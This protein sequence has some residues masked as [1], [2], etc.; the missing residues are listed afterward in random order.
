MRYYLILVIMAKMNISGNNRCWWGC[1]ERTL[2]RCWWECRVVRPL[3]KMVWRF[4]KKLKTELPCDL[5]IALL[6]I[7]PKGTKMLIQRGTCTPLF[8]AVLSTIAKLW[9]EP[10]CPSTDEWIKM[11]CVHVHA[12]THTHT[13]TQ[14]GILLHD[15]KEWNLAIAT[16]WMELECIMLS[17]ISQRKIHVWFHS[18]G[19]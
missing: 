5:A 17:E 7:Y 12:H 19:I 2:L 10:K 16:T 11:W 14:N 6:G 3:W 4:L 18:C 8:I 13:H 1:R 15:E 9:K